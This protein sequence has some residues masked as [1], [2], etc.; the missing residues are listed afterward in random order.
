MSTTPAD[1]KDSNLGERITDFLALIG[2]KLYNRILLGFFTS[3]GLVN[4][5]H[6]I[7]TRFFVHI[8]K[9]HEQ[10]IRNKRKD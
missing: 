6:K 9:Q 7:D 2:K 8:R 1:R 3:L 4:F 10:I 5:L